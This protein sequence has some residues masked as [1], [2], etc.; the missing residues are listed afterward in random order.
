MN[1]AIDS[2]PR[3][4][5]LLVERRQEATPNPPDVGGARGG[6]GDSASLKNKRFKCV[7][8]FSI[9]IAPIQI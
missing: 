5:K 1:F 9:L 2:A 7:L 3:A 8:A 6:G 4:F